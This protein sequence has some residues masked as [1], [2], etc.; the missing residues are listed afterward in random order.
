[1][2]NSQSR[3]AGKRNDRVRGIGMPMGK[4]RS[5][6]PE[7]I[8]ADA[9]PEQRGAEFDRYD[10]ELKA[11]ARPQTLQEAVDASMQIRREMKKK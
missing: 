9:T 10:A 8:P 11:N 5:K 7:S 4:R 1:M 3:A 6:R 2:G